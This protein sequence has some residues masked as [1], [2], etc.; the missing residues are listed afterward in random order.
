MFSGETITVYNFVQDKPAMS[1]AFV[2]E[3]D[4]MILQF[5]SI[6]AAPA[7]A[8]SGVS[9]MMTRRYG[10]RPVGAMIAPAGPS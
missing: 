6:G 5:I 9:Y 10:S 1:G 2:L 7:L 8:M 3:P 4:P